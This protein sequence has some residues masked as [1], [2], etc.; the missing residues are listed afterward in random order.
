M[1]LSL[2]II[3]EYSEWDEY[4]VGSP[5]DVIKQIQSYRKIGVTN[6]MAVMNFGGLEHH[7]VPSSLGLFGKCIIPAC[8]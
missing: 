8:K 7:K 2:S 5:D 6:F 4:L 1:L 3:Y